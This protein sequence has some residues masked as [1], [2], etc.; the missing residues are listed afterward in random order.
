MLCEAHHITRHAKCLGALWHHCTHVSIVL[1]YVQASQRPRPLLVRAWLRCFYVM[2][3]CAGHAIVTPSLLCA[4]T[5]IGASGT[6]QAQQTLP[7]KCS[8]LST[9]ARL[10]EKMVACGYSQSHTRN[11]ANCDASMRTKN[12][13][14]RPIGMANNHAVP[15][16]W[17]Q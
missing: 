2:R 6:T 12:N 8:R 17:Y 3:K 13:G 1:S 16:S 15:I 4:G 14:Y 5:R 7:R 9:F 10:R 11:R